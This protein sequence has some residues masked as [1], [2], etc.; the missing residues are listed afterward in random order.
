M[1]S[2]LQP[3]IVSI[4]HGL[5]TI[6]VLSVDDVQSIFDQLLIWRAPE[7][8]GTYVQIDTITLDGSSSYSYL[9]LSTSPSYCYKVQFYNSGSMVSSVFSEI[10]QESG[11]FNTYSIP[12]NSA[13]YPPELALSDNDREI[14]ESI[15]VAIGDMGEINIDQFDSSDPNSAYVCAEHISADRLTW[16]LSEE[17]GWPQR[18]ILNGTDK[19]SISD[20]KVLGYRYLTFAGTTPVITGTLTVWYNSFRFSDHEILLA[21]DRANNLLVFCPLPPQAITTEMR[22][23]QA[24]ILL[25]EGEIRNIRATSIG[26]IVDGDTSYDN[27]GLIQSRTE[28]LKDI[29]TKLRELINCTKWEISLHLDPIRVV[30]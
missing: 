16:T 12:V 2:V 11:T 23:M 4:I 24:T 21:Y 10:A 20:P 25:L 7:A 29:Q 14:I 9:D 26:K 18:V 30:F 19:T 22:V 5:L 3:D 15:R 13:T 28:D 8:N 6:S 1:T 17:R 27:S